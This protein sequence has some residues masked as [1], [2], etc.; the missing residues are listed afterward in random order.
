MLSLEIYPKQRF[1]Q[2]V[3]DTL[4]QLTERKVTFDKAVT[5]QDLINAGIA[6]ETYTTT[7]GGFQD[8][9][10]KQSHSDIP[11]AP[12]GV[13]AGGAFQFITISW[14]YPSY[15]GHSH[16]EIVSLIAITLQQKHF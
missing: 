5:F 8:Y 16:T 15:S 10:S 12:T 1:A 7:S 14:D 9:L 4:Q 11:T 13:T 3:N 2:S 6:K